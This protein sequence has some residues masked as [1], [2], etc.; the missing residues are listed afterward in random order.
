MAD[1]TSD[2]LN[3]LLALGETDAEILRL[4]KRLS[5]LPEQQQL[6]DAER[7][8][9]ELEDKRGDLGLER[10]RAQAEATRE[11]SEV[12]MLRA[13]LEAEQQRLYGG[14]ITNPKELA[15]MKHEIDGTQ[16]RIDEHEEA[17]LDA[18]ERA[19][20]IDTAIADLDRQLADTATRIDELTVQRDQAA[21]A[22]MA[23]IAEHEVTGERQREPLD[24]DLL[25]RYDQARARMGGRA[26]GRL[27]GESCTACGI[28]LSYADVN[29]LFEGPALGTCPNCQRLIVVHTG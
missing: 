4:N 20:Q 29:A 19:E 12:E 27:D 14:E 10:D 22:I 2:V 1:L 28:S 18:M 25:D 26:I 7:A 6:D 5:E 13:R 11:D 9:L 21:Q 17:E 15:S 24:A 8:R 23:E 3:G 16:R